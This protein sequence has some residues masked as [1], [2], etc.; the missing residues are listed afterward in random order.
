M[1]TLS[2]QNPAIALGMITAV[3]F[4][5]GKGIQNSGMTFAWIYLLFPWIGAI[6]AVIA[7]EFIFKRAT[8]V[9]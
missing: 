5:P 8:A 4:K 7:Y 2:S 9:V 1:G 3:V 6:L